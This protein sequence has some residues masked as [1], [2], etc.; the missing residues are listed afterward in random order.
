MTWSGRWSAR[1]RL[2]NLPGRGSWWVRDQYPPPGLTKIARADVARFVI[3]AL[4][5]SGYHHQTPAIC[6]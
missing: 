4:T 6:W 2:V 5:Q 3:G 1:P